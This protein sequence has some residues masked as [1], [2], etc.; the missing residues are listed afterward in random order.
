MYLHLNAPQV[1]D[2][3]TADE[4]QLLLQKVRDDL[5][6]VVT[7]LDASLQVK[8]LETALKHVIT[9]RYLISLENSI[10]SKNT[11]LGFAP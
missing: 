4:L 8:G 1:D 3:Q 6:E 11:R 10:K 7:K 9:L 2:A 5:Q